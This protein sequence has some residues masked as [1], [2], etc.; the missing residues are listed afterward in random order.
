VRPDTERI[1]DA[2]RR[3]Y[4]D[5]A[6]TVGAGE[7]GSGLPPGA[8][9]PAPLTPSVRRRAGWLI[10]ISVAAAVVLIVLAAVVVPHALHSGSQRAP[11]LAGTPGM[12]YVATEQDTLIPVDL[13]TGIALPAIRLGL[14][15]SIV[16]VV[17]TPDRKTLFVASVRGQVTPVDLATGQAGRPIL[18]GGISQA[19]VMTPDGRTAY[20]LEPPYGV[21]VLNLVADKPGRFIKVPDAFSFALTP[22]G[23]TLY[24]ANQDGSRVTPVATATGRPQRPIALQP[25]SWPYLA[26]SPDGRTVYVTGTPTGPGWATTESIMTPISTRTDSA[27]KPIRLRRFSAAAPITIS[28]D[29][30][31]AYLSDDGSVVPVSLRTGTVGKALQLPSSPPSPYQVAVSPDTRMIYASNGEVGEIYRIDAADGAPLA[32]VRVGAAGQWA[33]SPALFGNGGKTLYVLSYNEQQTSQTIYL[34]LLTPVDNATG[35]AG[36]SIRLRGVPASITFGS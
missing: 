9:D 19:M 24:V 14:K 18:V 5:L 17:V 4:T 20:L 21:A 1:D 12:A 26:M 10:P 2:L 11:D 29:G 35:K 34:G 6:A 30:R 36:K 31:T 8:S 28:P 13:R 25:R 22:D 23:S 7:A 32:P 16:G 3:A 27:G 33:P 15:G